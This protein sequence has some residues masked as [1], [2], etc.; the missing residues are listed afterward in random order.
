MRSTIDERAADR[1][2]RICEQLIKD[3]HDERR[4]MGELLEL[5]AALVEGARVSHAAD[6]ALAHIVHSGPC[7]G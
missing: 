6:T 5:G 3:S 4:S 7:R 1:L 2:R